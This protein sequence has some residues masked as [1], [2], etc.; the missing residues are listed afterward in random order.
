MVIFYAGRV[1]VFNDFPV[2]KANEIMMIATGQNQ[3]TTAVP[4]SYMVPSPAESTTNNI[5]VAVPGFDCLQYP[6]QPPLG[7][8]KLYSLIILIFIHL[9][10]K[11]KIFW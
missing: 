11:A 5:S 8:S 4:P 3:S 7:S 6:P 1:H 2:D 9:P 10:L